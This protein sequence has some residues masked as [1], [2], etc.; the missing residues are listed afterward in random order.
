MMDDKFKKK[1]DEKVYSTN[2]VEDLDEQINLY[3]NDLFL[4]KRDDM[5]E[6]G[7]QAAAVIYPNVFAAK[8][9]ENDGKGTHQNS[10]VN[11]TKYV[12]GDNNYLSEEGTGY[13][14]LYK[15]IIKQLQDSI[16]IRVLAKEEELVIS[17]TGSKPI[18]TD[19]Q[20]QTL[21][22]IL[23]KANEMKNSNSFN[24]V[25][26]GVA[27]PNLYFEHTN[28]SDELISGIGVNKGSL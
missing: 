25:M 21:K 15:D 6:E 1:L 16:Q 28:I 17:I 7:L 8:I 11:L 10:F 14:M 26:V 19:F 20:L 22:R 4:R 5:E 27:L 24:V 13:F 2:K 9:C 23:I 12:N 3:C 18:T